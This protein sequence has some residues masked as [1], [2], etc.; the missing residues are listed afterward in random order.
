M[1]HP[2]VGTRMDRTGQ[3]CEEL[4]PGP[5]AASLGQGLPALGGCRGVGRV[6]RAPAGWAGTVTAGGARGLLVYWID[7][8]NPLFSLHG[9]FSLTVVWQVLSYRSCPRQS[10]EAQQ[11][12]D[13]RGLNDNLHLPQTIISYHKVGSAPCT[14]LK[15][16]KKRTKPN[17]TT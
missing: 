5:A 13:T 1:D 6:S 4:E 12:I 3:G 8:L 15:E 14:I 17:R 7:L 10:T 16:K 9:S 11:K 2:G